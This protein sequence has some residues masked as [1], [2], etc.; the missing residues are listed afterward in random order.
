MQCD[1][2]V[3]TVWKMCNYLN[4]VFVPRLHLHDELSHCPGTHALHDI[5]FGRDPCISA[6][7]VA[8]R[9]D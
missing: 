3:P 8:F 4:I 9:L 2:S 6:A 1:C 5:N 7:L